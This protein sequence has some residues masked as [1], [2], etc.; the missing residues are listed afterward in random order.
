MKED[1]RQSNQA[2]IESPHPSAIST[3]SRSWGANRTKLGL[4]VSTVGAGRPNLTRRQS[5]Q[6]GIERALANQSG[7]CVVTAPIEP[8]WD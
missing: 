3:P 8:S 5:N 6:A 4:K 1:R 7:R 2:G